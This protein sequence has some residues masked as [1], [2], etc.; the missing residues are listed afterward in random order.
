MS[1]H[2]IWVTKL[3]GA[4]TSEFHEQLHQ[5][6]EAD[7]DQFGLY[8]Q[9]KVFMKKEYSPDL[10]LQLLSLRPYLP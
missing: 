4:F 6:C 10:G 2:C 8:D 7:L 1:D 5:A 3:A 9:H